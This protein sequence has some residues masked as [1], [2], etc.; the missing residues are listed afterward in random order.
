MFGSL[1][2]GAPSVCDAVPVIAT[3]LH[4]SAGPSTIHELLVDVDAW[5]VWSPHVARVDADARRVETGWVGS[6]RAFFSPAPTSMVVDDVRADGGYTW[7]STVGPWRLDYENAV[8]ADEHGSILR[9]T[10]T[11]DGPAGAFIERV[12]APLSSL[13]QRR[14]MARLARLAE[15]V[16]QHA[17]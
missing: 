9:F 15:L 7:H 13:G 14:R 10:A 3:E 6:A 11:L 4:S 16:E 2:P 17:G 5:N 1:P 12:V 8:A